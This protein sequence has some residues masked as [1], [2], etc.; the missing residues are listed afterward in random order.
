MIYIYINDKL[1][2]S[3]PTN[4][5]SKQKQQQQQQARHKNKT[6]FFDKS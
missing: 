6:V 2:T 3:Y 5:S 4:Q 1:A